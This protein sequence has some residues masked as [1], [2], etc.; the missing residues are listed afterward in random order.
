M[1]KI[2]VVRP[3]T[4]GEEIANTIS[5]GMGALLAMAGAVPL[6]VK[7]VMTGSGRAVVGVSLYAA[8]L[9]ALYVASTVYH[10]VTAP[11]AK[12]TL[13]VVDHCSIF[14]LILGTY[15]PLAL[16]TLGGWLGWVLIAVNAA[17][18]VVG[19]TLKVI[20]LNRFNKL[21][22]VLYAAMG[23]L[24]FPAI[25]TVASVLPMAGFL[26]LLSGGIAYT[27]GIAFYTSKKHYMHFVFHLFVLLG[28]ILQYF[29]VLL[30]CV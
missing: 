11:G 22:L 2:K 6:I 9:I 29:C 28:S 15:I 21:S 26:L 7:A 10:G 25:R 4:R 19:I 18:A 1:V 17:L 27:L 3:Q 23:W 14:L 20:D 16:L 12:R 5:H 30:Y 13:R 24:I 8:S